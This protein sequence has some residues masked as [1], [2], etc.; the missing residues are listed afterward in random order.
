MNATVDRLGAEPRQG[1]VLQLV[2]I[3]EPHRVH[4]R[5]Q[6][7]TWPK[8]FLLQGFGVDKQMSQAQLAFA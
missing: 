8:W 7:R 1:V 6:K 2:L 3:L 5:S 4:Q